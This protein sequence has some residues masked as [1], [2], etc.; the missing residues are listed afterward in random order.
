MSVELRVAVFTDV[1]GNLEG[2]QAVLDDIATCGPFDSIVAGGDYCVKGPDPAACFDIVQEASDAMLIGNTDDDLIAVDLQDPE[3]TSKKRAAIK[4]SKKQLGKDRLER[5]ARL[6]FDASFVAPDGSSLRVVHANPHDLTRHIFPDLPDLELSELLEDLD[7]D[8]LVFGHLHMPYHRT[9]N[10]VQLF[11][12]AAAGLPQD[13]D[14]RA[15]WGA[16]EW[17]ADSGWR[18]AIRRVEYDFGNTV[19]RIIES[20]MPHRVRR[21]HELVSASYV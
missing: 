4:W 13:G 2:L 3:L 21:I 11:D 20:G 17:S 16:F 6:P 8:V 15:T 19:L 12:V 5:I 7:S 10:G 9:F 14:R 1:H 18:G